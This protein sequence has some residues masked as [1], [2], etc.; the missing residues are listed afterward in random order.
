MELFKALKF[1]VIG[2]KMVLLEFFSIAPEVLD[3]VLCL[4]DTR[5][6]DKRRE[7]EEWQEDKKKK[8]AEKERILNKFGTDRVEA[9]QRPVVASVSKLVPFSGQ[10]KVGCS[11]IGIGKNTGGG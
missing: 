11:D 2:Q 3:Y 7:L 8:A 4:E 5:E 10:P 9:S 6:E 1:Q